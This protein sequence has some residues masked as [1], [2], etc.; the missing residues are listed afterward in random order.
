MQKTHW[1]KFVGKFRKKELSV[2]IDTNVFISYLWGSKN[3]EE[4]AELL[5]IG[6]IRPVVS[7]A[8]LLE[9]LS[10]GNR[11]KFK[12]RFTPDVFRSLYDAYKDISLVVVPEKKITASKDQ[13]DN[14]FL[15]CAL[16]VR[17]DYIITGDQHLLK[18]GVYESVHIVTPAE[19]LKITRRTD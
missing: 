3:A 13:N 17:A 5:F 19:F 11:G 7:E 15:E 9:L 2:V 14:I 16:E 18:I 10:V 1:Q 12:D 8:I 4:I 6:R